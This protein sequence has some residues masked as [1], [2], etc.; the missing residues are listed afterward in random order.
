MHIASLLSAGS[1]LAVL[2]SASVPVKRDAASSIWSQIENTTTC[3]GCQTLLI[4]LQG[5]AHLGNA[6]FTSVITDVCIKAGVEDPDVCRGAIG[7]EGPILAHDLRQ[8]TVGSHTA[9]LFCNTVFGLCPFPSVTTYN[10]PFPSPKPATSRPA[11][12]GKTPIEVVHYSDIHVDLSYETGANYN[13]TKNICCRP[14]TSA[15]APGNTSYPAGPFGNHACDSPASLEESMYAAI[16]E[17]APNAAFTLFTGDVVEGAVWLVNET[18]V[19]N[20]LQSAYS[21]MIALGKVYGTVG[22]HDV[23]PV[24]SFP[25]AAVV[26]TISSQWVYDT[27]SSLWQTWIGSAASATADKNPGSYSVVHPGSN[28]RIIS[29][30]TNMYYKQNFWLYEAKM[31]TDPSGQLAWLVNELQ[32]AEDAGQRAYIIGH[33]PMGSGDTFHD[34]SNYFDQIVNRYAATIAALFFGHTHKDQFQISYTDYTAQSA[35]NAVEVSYIAP[36]LTPTSG[37]PAF[38]V[39]SVDPDTFAVLDITTY[40]ADM[41]DPNYQTAG[42]TWTKYYSVKEAYGPLVTPPLTDASAELTPAFWHKL[43]EVFSS[44]QTAFDEYHVRKTRGYDLSSCTGTCAT[45][46]ICQLRA[47]QAQYNCV[48]VSPGVHFKRD[49]VETDVAHGAH[50]D[51]CEGSPAKSILNALMTNENLREEIETKTAELAKRRMK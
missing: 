27:L 39:Y 43:T 11:V 41:S 38:R 49:D 48:T 8:M 45:Q 5:L 9:Q 46:D 30:N 36:A 34:G 37:M 13:C 51:S 24:N 18:E 21:K 31:E 44:N 28:L 4:T 23:A 26:T 3:S 32:A 47:A 15:D 17:I 16:Q 10:V 6:Q 42:P 20:D 1:A 2:A 22:N 7:L 40:I 29:I 25:P 50:G 12:S 35:A 19:T 14:Y 33:M